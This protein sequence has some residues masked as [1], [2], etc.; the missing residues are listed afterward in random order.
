MGKKIK[1]DI[2]T[3]V[4]NQISVTYF[5]LHGRA[6]FIRAMLHYKGIEFTNEAIAQEEW[7]NVKM[8]GRFPFCSMPLVVMDGIAMNQSKAAGRA[9]AIKYGFYSTDPK[10]IHAI[11]ALLD[12]A[13]EMQLGKI[14]GYFFN[15]NKD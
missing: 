4:D 13:Q 8:S 11:D 15:P 10:I 12:Y 5:G 1:K 14:L 6:E 2:L 9:I 3:M 7:P